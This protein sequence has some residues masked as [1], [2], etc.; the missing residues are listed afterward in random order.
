MEAVIQEEMEELQELTEV[1]MT[2][3]SVR[4]GSTSSI[5]LLLP[6]TSTREENTLLLAV[7]SEHY[8][9]AR[10]HVIIHHTVTV[11]E[12]LGEGFFPKSGLVGQIWTG[13]LKLNRMDPEKLS[14]LSTNQM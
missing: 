5:T 8:V 4:R 11:R 12:L 13:V 9:T 1:L 2:L 10:R 14:D 3:L 6:Y 7:T